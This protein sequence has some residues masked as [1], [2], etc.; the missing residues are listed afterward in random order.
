MSD[1]ARIESVL[2]ENRLFPP[3]EG[4]SERLG[5][6]LVANLDQW[7]E[8]HE[9]ALSDPSSYWGEVASAFW[10]AQSWD[11]V[12]QGDMP[13]T[14]W[15]DGGKTNVCFN[16][17]DRHV[18]DGHGAEVGLVW[19][20]EP[21]GEQ[22]PEIRRLTWSMLQEEVSRTANALRELGVESGDVVTIY[23]GMVPE[24]AITMLACARIGAVHSV[25]FGGF[26]ASAIADRVQ[27][28]QSRLV[29]T[30]DGSWRRGSVVP[31]K[32]NVDEALADIDLVDHVLVLRR[33]HNDIKWKEMNRNEKE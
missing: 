8:Q 24:L 26:S 17:V 6:A 5:G 15:F 32:A 2:N 31:L 4:I 14:R 30:C 33:C 27:D 16:C 29:V 20:G 11:A 18:A 9:Y 23:M 13:D 10:W 1:D 7:Q 22:G 19:E 25:I 3:P 21:I 28:A 12:L